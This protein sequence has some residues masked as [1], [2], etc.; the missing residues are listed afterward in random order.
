MGLFK[1]LVTEEQIEDYA[2][3]FMSRL[4]AAYLAG[5]IGENEYHAQVKGLDANCRA[6]YQRCRKLP[7]TYFEPDNELRVHPRLDA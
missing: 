6:M 1:H 2:E 4:D 5:T 3:R 7:R